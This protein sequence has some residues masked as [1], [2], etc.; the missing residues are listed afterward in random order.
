MPSC[1]RCGQDNPQGFRFC[2]ACGAPLAAAPRL[3]DEERKVITVL[4]CDLVGFTARSDQA[5]PEDVGAMLRP[6]HVR[7]RREIERFGGSL[8]KFIGDA[9]MAVFGAPAA[10][11]DDPERAVR[12]AARMLE[13]IVELN[14]T[15]PALAL[16]V[17]IGIT[18][19]EA[20]VVL[21]PGGETEG[22]V[23]D[24]V[25]TASRL[26]GVAPVN[27]ILVSEGTWRATHALFAYDAGTGP[28]QGQGAARAGVATGRVAQS[29]GVDVD[30]R[31][32]APFIGRDVELDR[33]KGRYT[34]TLRERSVSLVT[35][36]GEPGVGKSRLIHEFS[37]FVD[38]R[39][40]F[41]SW[42]QGR[43]L[44]YGDGITF[45][46]LGEI[47]KAQAGILESDTPVHVATK[48]VWARSSGPVRW[49]QSAAVTS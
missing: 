3:A 39:Q 38:D 8:D 21:K 33:L 36:L 35:M 2:G 25:N 30:Q 1:S 34:R 37:R 29:V 41:V 11:E 17:R 47:A 15:Q 9:V 31:P 42:R 46:A 10:H 22:V 43:C 23:G 44:P 24:I 7:L 28:A 49:P 32:V 40:E 12:C 26:Q 20:L 48:L 18:T 27:G 45:W 14:A 16:S 19:G 4:F 6:Y 5:D 13:A